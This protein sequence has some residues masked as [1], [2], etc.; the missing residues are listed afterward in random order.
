[1]KDITADVATD[2]SLLSRRASIS[3]TL[4]EL[5]VV[6][7]VIAILASLF[8]PA[9]GRARNK[10]L[11]TQ[12]VSNMKQIGNVFQFYNG[13]YNEYWPLAKGQLAAT[14]SITWRKALY[15]A[16][17][18]KHE[19]EIGYS[20]YWNGTKYVSGGPCRLFCPV[21]EK[22]QMV[23]T[24]AYPC[25]GGDRS[26]GGHNWLATPIYTKSSE[27][28]YHSALVTLVESGSEGEGKTEYSSFQM[29]PNFTFDNHD[30]KSNFLFADGHVDTRDQFFIGTGITVWEK[31]HTRLVVITSA[32]T[33][34]VPLFD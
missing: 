7:A 21:A 23:R 11:S 13:D 18:T 6:I 5:L 31:F 1:M 29:R 32:G 9:L 24:Y 14:S 19:Q 4:V 10:A 3:F 15:D 34:P 20:K 22:N 12:C 33:R 27:I 16:G 30:S 2:P 28:K 8:L 26:V 17:L 25:T